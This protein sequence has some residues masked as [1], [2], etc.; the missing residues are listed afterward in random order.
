MKKVLVILVI[1]V[2]LLTGCGLGVPHQEWVPQ[3]IPLY[4]PADDTG[5]WKLVEGNYKTLS[6]I[7]SE[8]PQGTSPGVEIQA[9][10]YVVDAPDIEGQ[11]YITQE[12]G[13]VTIIQE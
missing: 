2:L 10:G 1:S 3:S 6:K 13:T 12:D 8:S 5:Y 7:L 4:A 9:S 11:E